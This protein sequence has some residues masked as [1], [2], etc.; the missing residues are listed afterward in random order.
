M[1]TQERDNLVY[2]ILKYST[3]HDVCLAA[4]GYP[5]AKYIR[6][7]LAQHGFNNISGTTLWTDGDVTFQLTVRAKPGT[8]HLFDDKLPMKVTRQ[9]LHKLVLVQGFLGLSCFRFIFNQEET[10]G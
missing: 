4:P 9:D 7:L 10:N 5:S 2:T 8:E 6:D 3:G 1:S